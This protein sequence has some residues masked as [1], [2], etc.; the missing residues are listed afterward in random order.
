M[1]PFTN[2]I[3]FFFFSLLALSSF[4]SCNT[5]K[6]ATARQSI[7]MTLLLENGKT[8]EYITTTYAD[9]NPSNVKPSSR[10]QNQ[11]RVFFSCTAKEKVELIKALEADLLVLTATISESEGVEIQSSKNQKS[12]KARPGGNQ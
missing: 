7:V 5:T 6:E 10:S 11:Y 3:R 4:S 2:P 1:K 8:G 9:Y 12:A